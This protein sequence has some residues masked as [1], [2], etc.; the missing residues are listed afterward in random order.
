M[1]VDAK[2]EISHQS[3]GDFIILGLTPTHE[4]SGLFPILC[5]SIALPIQEGSVS[6]GQLIERQG[7]WHR[8][9]LDRPFT[10]REETQIG[11]KLGTSLRKATDYPEGLYLESDQQRIEVLLPKPVNRTANAILPLS[12]TRPAF[13]PACDQ[14]FTEHRIS[15]PTSLNMMGSLWNVA[16]LQ[17]LFKRLQMSVDMD[18]RQGWPVEYQQN[19]RQ[20]TAFHLSLSERG[21]RLS[22]RDKSGFLQGQAYLAQFLMQWLLTGVSVSC[23]LSGSAKYPYRGVHLDVVRHFFS[24]AQIQDWLDIFALY[25][26][27]YFHWH[28]TDDDGWRIASNAF[29]ELTELGAWR[30]PDSALPPQMG[31][32]LHRYGGIYSAEE[33][34][35]LVEHALQLGIQV[36]PEMDLPG[37]ARA[38]LKAIPSLVELADR[39][40]YRSVQH[41]NDNV[42]NPAYGDT[43]EIIET[44]IKE[45]CALFPAPLFHIG[46]DEIPKGVWQQSPAALEWSKQTGR[47]I[48]QLQGAF[49]HHVESCLSAQGKTMAGWEEVVDG[50]GTSTKTWVFSWQGTQAGLEAAQAGHPVVMT[51]A[52][53]C[54]FDLARTEAFDDPGYWWAGTVDLEKAYQY[55]PE[56][57]FDAESAARIQ[58]VQYCLWTELVETPAQAEF[59]WFPRLLAGAEV[60]FGS[61]TNFSFE[62]FKTRADVHAQLLLRLGIDLKA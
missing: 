20:V 10:G 4:L 24:A 1:H 58:G 31:T 17:R 5:F 45:W 39:S 48:P 34:S 30:G 46:S 23:E 11:F 21:A 37:H 41:H 53:Y 26:F 12:N 35:A 60:V 27:N 3:E 25:H 6:G 18:D 50:G 43:I 8:V 33:V 29:P 61:N 52:Q 62:S 16:W 49:L 14:S 47:A 15:A 54:Y 9:V 56:A 28:L 13:I 7:D 44:L 59:M 57:G 2:I 55:E 32:G 42:I 51:P 36:M 22:Y 19:T 38:L 40:E